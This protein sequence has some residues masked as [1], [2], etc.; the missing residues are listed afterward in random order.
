VRSQADEVVRTI[1]IFMLL[2][3]LTPKPVMIPFVLS[4]SIEEPSKLW[5]MEEEDHQLALMIDSLETFLYLGDCWNELREV[6]V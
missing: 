6:P 5:L 2:Q 1:S 4:L 3:S